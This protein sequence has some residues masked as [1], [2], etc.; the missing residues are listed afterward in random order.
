MKDWKEQLKEIQGQIKESEKPVIK[1]K[2]EEKCDLKW[3]D[4]HAHYHHGK[5][6][7][8]EK[9][10]LQNVKKDVE[11]VITLGTG[12]KSNKQTLKLIE[13]YDFMYGMIGFFPTECF[14]ME[15]PNV[16]NEFIYQLNN[17]KII[18]IGEIGL[19]YN[20]DCV[21]CGDKKIVR[22]E[23]R[24]IQKKWLRY[25]LDLAAKLNLPVSL[26]SRDAEEDTAKIFN[27]YEQ[28]KGV[29]H[30]F[31]YGLE[32][33]KL[34]VNKG[35][36]LGIGGT[37]TY[38]GN[39]ELREVIKEI[40]LDKLLLETDCPYLSPEPKRGT[41]NTSSNIIYVIKNIAEIKGVSE[42]EVIRQTNENAKKLFNL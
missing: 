17:K 23:A 15:D 16:L 1:K 38:K 42:E 29:M 33:A 22:E 28:I 36:Y 31:S 12:V 4:T 35:L 30:C 40:S 37:S 41:L 2:N 20:W 27:E 21:Q 11:Y 19:D 25:Q 32:T 9:E 24:N 34:Y 6:K 13:K 3:I 26:H 8:K 7:N 18:G 39:D 14:D 5:F 10:L